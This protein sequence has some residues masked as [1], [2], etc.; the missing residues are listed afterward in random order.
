ME[1][2]SIALGDVSGVA[3]YTAENDGY[4]VATTLAPSDSSTP[5]RFVTTLLPGQKAILS[6]LREPG[7][8]PISVEI[9][10]TGDRVTVTKGH[11]LANAIAE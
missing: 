8:S 4:R 11:N 2:S 6:V 7:L 1:A 5:V 10:R 3:Y 9:S